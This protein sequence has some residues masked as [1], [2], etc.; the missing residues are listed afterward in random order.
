[1]EQISPKDATLPPKSVRK[2]VQ[3]EALNNLLLG[4]Q[5]RGSIVKDE[6]AT[7]S[8]EPLPPPMVSAEDAARE[9]AVSGENRAVEHVAELSR[10]QAVRA[11]S[12]TP[13][14][15]AAAVGDTKPKRNKKMVNNK[16]VGTT[17]VKSEED[18]N[19]IPRRRRL[20]YKSKSSS[21]AP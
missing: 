7:T 17:V 4:H 11:I 20:E 21:D 5:K 6:E 14:P 13:S 3:V 19:R 15:A 1:M 18:C 2:V 8:C 9:K 16:R 10:E 12:V